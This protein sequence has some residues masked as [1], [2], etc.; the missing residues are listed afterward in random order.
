M[1][2]RKRADPKG[3]GPQSIVEGQESKKLK[4]IV[5]ET[6]FSGI[7]DEFRYLIISNCWIKNSDR[8]IGSAFS[9]FYVDFRLLTST[10]YGSLSS[11]YNRDEIPNIDLELQ[12]I[13]RGAFVFSP[14][15][16][17]PK[18][19]EHF[20]YRNCTIQ[21]A[22]LFF[23]NDKSEDEFILG[24]ILLI[25]TDNIYEIIRWYSYIHIRYLLTRSFST[26]RE[27]RN[28]RI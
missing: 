16:E 10:W 2:I 19:Y 8:T 22:E 26:E 17:R 11:K 18:G 3:F 24:T 20:K 21:Q 14:L 9:K 4:L 6:H 15:S 27:A 12:Q 5:G 25:R 28:Y 23:E 7:I 13:N 1:G